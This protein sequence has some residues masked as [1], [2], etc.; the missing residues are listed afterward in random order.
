MF[1]SA[2][3]ARVAARQRPAL[4]DWVA[5][6]HVEADEPHIRIEKTGEDPEHYTIWADPATLPPYV[7]LVQPV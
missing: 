5:Q 4:G 1:A 7:E 2:A 3:S 6:L